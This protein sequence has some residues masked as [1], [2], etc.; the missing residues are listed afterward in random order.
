M[1][2]FEY[3]V[4]EMPKRATISWLNTL[5]NNGWQVIMI[6]TIRSGFLGLKTRE[7][8]ICKREKE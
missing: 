7:F 3:E 8:M 1:K 2:R 5:G 4:F 6:E